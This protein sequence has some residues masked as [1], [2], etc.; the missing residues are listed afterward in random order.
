MNEDI[1]ARIDA[2]DCDLLDREA[3]RQ[4]STPAAVPVSAP[5]ALDLWHVIYEAAAEEGSILHDD[6]V[7]AIEKAVRFAHART[8]A[9]IRGLPKRLLVDLVDDFQCWRAT[10]NGDDFY[11]KWSDI[12]ALLTPPAGAEQESR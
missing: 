10:V 7:S 5:P 3:E 9:Q 1:E 12:H 6:T 4:R 8:E 2:V 11:V